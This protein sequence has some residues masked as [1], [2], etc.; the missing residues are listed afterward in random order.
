MYLFHFC[1]FFSL[2]LWIP[3]WAGN[4]TM[5]VLPDTL[6]KRCVC[7]GEAGI[8]RHPGKAIPQHPTPI[9]PPPPTGSGRSR[10]VVSRA[11]AQWVMEKERIPSGTDLQP[12]MDEV[13]VRKRGPRLGEWPPA[14]KGASE[15]SPEASAFWGA[16]GAKRKSHQ[17]S[18]VVF[19]QIYEFT[20]QSTEGHIALFLYLERERKKRSR[21]KKN[22]LCVFPM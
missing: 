21:R 7:R 9:P 19:S 20:S 3:V 11:K 8:V 15:V 22:S 6:M 18:N 17:S 14:S 4:G 5:E 2:R 12:W 13:T 1:P 16:G 10:K